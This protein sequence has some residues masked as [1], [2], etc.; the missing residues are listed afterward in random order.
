MNCCVSD[1]ADEAAAIQ[2]L[3]YINTLEDRFGGEKSRRIYIDRDELWIS[4]SIN[5]LRIK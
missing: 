5:Q 1:T 2:F 3:S 4:Y